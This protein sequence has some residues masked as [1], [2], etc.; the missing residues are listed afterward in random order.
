LEQ[1]FLLLSFYLTV[2]AIGG[3]FSANACGE[4]TPWATFGSGDIERSYHSSV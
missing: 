2:C 4:Q 1:G 3:L